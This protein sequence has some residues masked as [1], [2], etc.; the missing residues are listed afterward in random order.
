MSASR[1]APSRSSNGGVQPPTGDL[2]DVVQYQPTARLSYTL[3][4][5]LKM[6]PIPRQLG[7]MFQIG[8]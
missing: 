5:V 1:P 8:G 7:Y 3:A 2:W 4:Q 6:P